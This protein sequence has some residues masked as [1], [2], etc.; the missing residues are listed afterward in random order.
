M[1]S[2]I[3]ILLLLVMMG[4]ISAPVTAKNQVEAEGFYIINLGDNETINIAKKQA[5]ADAVRQAVKKIG[6]YIEGYSKAEN[7][8]IVE[9]ELEILTIDSM[10]ITSEFYKFN[11]YGKT[12]QV[13]AQINISYDENEL[14][15][16]IRNKDEAALNQALNQKEEMRQ[17][18]LGTEAQNANISQA[19]TVTAGESSN[20]ISQMLTDA[21]DLIDVLD[22]ESAI[23]ILDDAIK[24]DN[25]SAVAYYL[26]A[27]AYYKK[28]DYSSANNDV[29]ESLRL[30]PDFDRAVYLQTKIAT[31]NRQ[32]GA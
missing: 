12:I 8:Q 11:P 21:R 9:D 14:M 25:Q 20:G 24:K 13:I 3:T 16:K 32:G 30:L 2:I 7:L 28:G 27:Q 6:V 1:K 4:G 18:I 10:T 15:E 23:A 19:I 29:K 22:Y 17:L 5:K 31:G 26:R